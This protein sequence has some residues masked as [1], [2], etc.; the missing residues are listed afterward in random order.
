MLYIGI[1]SFTTNSA[2]F[3][4]NKAGALSLYITDDMVRIVPLG[5]IVSYSKYYKP[6]DVM[7]FFPQNIQYKNAYVHTVNFYTYII[8]HI[9]TVVWADICLNGG[10][11]HIDVL[12]RFLRFYVLRI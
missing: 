8:L 4:Y 7:P 12:S 6:G 3:V 2:A 11:M 9:Q 5:N 1:S 10:S